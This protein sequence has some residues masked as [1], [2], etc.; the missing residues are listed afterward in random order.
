MEI[1]GRI[2]RQ[3]LLFSLLVL[4]VSM[5]IFPKK[6]GTML[7]EAPL[8]NVVF[9][10]VFYGLV[11]HLLNRKLSPLQLISSAGLCLIY[12]FALGGGVGLLIVALY[13]WKLKTA[14]LAGMGSYL[15]GMLLQIVAAPFILK[16]VIDSLHNPRAARRTRPAASTNASDA[17]SSVAVSKEK[18]FSKTVPTYATE[19][20]AASGRTAQ[21]GTSSSAVSDGNGF[22]RATRYIGED[23]S[24]LVAAVVDKEGLLLGNFSRR[25]VDAEEWAPFA[26]TLVEQNEQVVSKLACDAPEKIDILFDNKRIVVACE[27][28]YSLMVVSERATD[29]VLN[30]RINQGLEIIRKYVVER[31]SDKLI[32]NAEKAYV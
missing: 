11:V 9:E 7:P 29:D 28:A 2:A 30:I 3:I 16:P 5:V 8:V 12:R 14:L 23:G 32:G 17:T 6:Y 19:S 18:G 27:K 15:P 24:V 1:S 21:T 31:Y 20:P 13:S 26:L 10:L 25:G 22:E 4:T